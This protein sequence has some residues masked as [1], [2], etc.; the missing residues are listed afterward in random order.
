MTTETKT[1][2]FASPE[3][4][5]SAKIQE[6]ASL[7]NRSLIQT[8]YDALNT[9]VMIL[10]EQ[11]QIVFVNR[12]LLEL[13]DAK[14]SEAILGKRPGEA[15]ECLHAAEVSGCGTT[16]FCRECGAVKAILS[17]QTTHQT[18]VQDCHILRG[19]NQ[20]AL[21][22]RVCAAPLD[23]ENQRFTVF[24][25]EDISDSERR[26]S[27]ER[28]F[29]HD[30][31]NTAVG[32]RGLGEL[33]TLADAKDIPEFS[34]QIYEGADTLVQE[35][36]SQ[37]ELL[38]AENRELHVDLVP[39]SVQNIL[40]R[41]QAIYRNHVVTRNKTLQ[42]IL[43]DQPLQVLSDQ[44]LLERIIGNMT[45]N[46]L[47]ASKEGQTVTISTHH[48]GEHVIFVVH[49]PGVMPEKI[50]VQ[51]FQRSFSTKGAGRGLGT[52]S[53]KLI[54]E[55]YLNGAVSFISN[56]AKGTEFYGLFPSPKQQNHPNSRSTAKPIHAQLPFRVLVVD[57]VPV[58]A[59]VVSHL[60]KGLV[61]EVATAHSGR[62][63]VEAAASSY[64]HVILMDLELPDM[65]GI[66][67]T[68]AILN[69]CRENGKEAPC[70]IGLSAHRLNA[71]AQRCTDAGMQGYLTKPVSKQQLRDKLATIFENNPEQP[72]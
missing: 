60:L 33:L 45:K 46:A 49:N 12:K 15:F 56:P 41:I 57:D 67:T 17:S 30:I 63:A 71:T 69:S 16:R 7:F 22:L 28:I 36:E 61:K 20:D 10:N 11:R 68:Q 39:L 59:K 48:D 47:E 38:A 9:I 44:P 13:F 66:E 4:A 70:I 8:V 24:S 1:T 55:R 42:V 40:A 34:H 23:V 29:F 14:T 32:M 2:Y 53:M 25:I 58:N 54:S 65:S 50:Q 35:I 27:L 6:Q 5:S 18:D 21:T 51:I 72:D 43:P 26:K 31:M 3:R 62:E 64:F 52:Y 37:R 19:G